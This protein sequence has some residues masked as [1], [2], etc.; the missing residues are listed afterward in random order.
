MTTFQ[1]EVFWNFRIPNSFR[2]E[3]HTNTECYI[4]GKEILKQMFSEYEIKILFVTA[5]FFNF[6]LTLQPETRLQIFRERYGCR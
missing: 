3:L 5:Y 4:G 1:L 2:F 6:K